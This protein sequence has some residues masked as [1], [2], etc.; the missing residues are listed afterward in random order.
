MLSTLGGQKYYN[1]LIIM[2]SKFSGV[3]ITLKVSNPL[4]RILDNKTY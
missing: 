1:T 2:A 3:F 4:L